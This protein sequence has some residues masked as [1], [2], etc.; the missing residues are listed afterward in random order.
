MVQSEF[1]MMGTLLNADDLPVINS[2]RLPDGG[3]KN[4]R[5]GPRPNQFPRGIEPWEGNIT[6]GVR[7][8]NA[9]GGLGRARR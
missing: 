3:R 8:G 2:G 5:V 6:I 9:V 4:L 7:V 1:N